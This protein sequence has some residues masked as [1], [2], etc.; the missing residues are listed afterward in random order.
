VNFTYQ[1]GALTF[2]AAQSVQIT[3]TGGSVPFTA[4]Y[5]PGSVSATNLI[6][7]TPGSGNTPGAI[8]LAVNQAVLALLAPG[9]YTGTVVVSAASIP[10]GSQA[11]NVTVTVNGAPPPVV[12]TLD[13]AASLQP[14]A[15]SPGEIVTFFGSGMG[16]V[17]GVSFVL[18]NGKLPTT[19]AGVTVSFNGVAA[20][21]LY[22]SSSQINALVPYEMAGQ[23]AANVVVTYTNSSSTVFQARITDS[24][25]AI[26]S[27]SQGGNGQGAI[28]NQNYSG[29]GAN[30][31]AAK[32]SIVQ[33]FGTG[34]GQLVPG[35]ATGSITPGSPPFPMPIDKVTVTIGGVSAQ[36]TYAGEAPGLIAGLLQVDAVV[37]SNIG[38]GAQIVM[39]TIGNNS[40]IQQTITVFVQ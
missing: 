25:P 16:P 7:V 38:S 17:S 15:V 39:L 6:T 22:V 1:A 18:V 20:P 28:L 21:L 24:A 33:I 31:P 9:T 35:V 30:S 11:I 2:P 10:N 37:P 23:V 8:S 40:N 13:N 4:T 34:E 5:T 27:A 32:G 26:F 12:V 36:V 14:G 29:N 19:I 3:S